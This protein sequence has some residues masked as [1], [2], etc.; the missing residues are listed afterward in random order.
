[1]YSGLIEITGSV[2]KITEHNG[3]KDFV[4]Y[5]PTILNDC[6]IGDSLGVNG[7][8]L[9]VTQFDDQYFH[10]TAVPET[11]SKT[12]L[13]DLQVGDAVNL[14]R[15]VKVGDRVGGHTIQ[16][17]VDATISISAIKIDGAA[18]N[19]TFVV[20]KALRPYIVKKGF[21]ALDGMSI[22]VVN[23]IA[24]KF[25]V[26]LIPHT[27]AVTIA[28]HY[29]VGSKVNLEVDMFA[30]YVESLVANFAKLKEQEKC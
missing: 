3:S 14:E 7:V 13:N 29:K 15:C 5:A 2:K 16:G 8:C 18:W 4:F 12:N 30:K 6:K 28:K 23:V 22:T 21:V 1:M 19:I 17:H 27:R 11:L 20:P 26:T 25:S 10:A 9:T 24:D